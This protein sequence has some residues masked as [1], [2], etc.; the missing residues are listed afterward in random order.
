MKRSRKSSS[1]WTKRS[2]HDSCTVDHSA[3]TRCTPQSTG[4]WSWILNRTSCFKSPHYFDPRSTASLDN[5]ESFS[6]A[7]TPSNPLSCIIAGRKFCSRSAWSSGLARKRWLWW[8]GCRRSQTQC[9]LCRIWSLH[10]C[11]VGEAQRCC[12]HVLV[13]RVRQKFSIVEV[14]HYVDFFSGIDDA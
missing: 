3:S 1:S 10:C 8:M 2:R 4:E 14:R 13:K 7:W 11:L 12:S 6:L 5:I 9:Q